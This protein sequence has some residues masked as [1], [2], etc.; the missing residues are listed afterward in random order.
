MFIRKTKVSCFVMLGFILLGCNGAKKE[1]GK[2]ILNFTQPINNVQQKQVFERLLQ[3]YNELNPNVEVKLEMNQ[4]YYRKILVQMAGNSAPDVFFMHAVTLPSF[5]AKGVLLELEDYIKQEKIDLNDFYP[6]ALNSL[7]FNGKIYGLPEG[8]TPFVL[9]Y[10]KEIFD[11]KK[12]AYPNDNWTWKEFLDTAIKLTERDN[13][14]HITNY[15]FSMHYNI[16][17]VAVF[18]YQNGGKFFS[19]DGKKLVMNSPES[20]QAYKFFVDLSMKHKVMPL[21]IEQGNQMTWDLFMTGRVA[22]IIDGRWMVPLYKDAKFK[23]NIAMLP[24]GK[25]KKSLLTINAY[26]VNAKTKYPKESIKLLNFI[27]TEG[28]KLNTRYGLEVPARKSQSNVIFEK[29]L[30]NLPAVNNKAFIESIKYG[31]TLPTFTKFEEAVYKVSKELE[32]VYQGKEDPDTAITNATT[33]VNKFLS[34]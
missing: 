3:K 2:I 11:R 32:Y 20:R 16:D 15:G 25:Y 18:M 7:K 19:E 10:N 17:W 33:E 13:A 1:T 23:W 30:A 4:D 34:E 24:K 14:G 28:A 26:C 29:P 27:I 6:Q 22:M 5:A 9:F 12:V 21:A 31:F 8:C